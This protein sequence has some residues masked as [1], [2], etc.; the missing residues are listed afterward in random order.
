VE[1][2]AGELGS[3]PDVESTRLADD[4]L[5]DVHSSRQQALIKVEV[6]GDVSH[7]PGADGDR[8]LRRSI[9]WRLWWE[10]EVIA[11]YLMM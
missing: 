8:N 2:D 11:V 9:L 6:V 1:R 5:G 4:E 3:P 7:D 10:L